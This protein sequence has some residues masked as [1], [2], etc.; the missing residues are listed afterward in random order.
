MGDVR[1]ERNKYEAL[2]REEFR[3][4]LRMMERGRKTRLDWIAEEFLTEGGKSSEEW[5]RRAFNE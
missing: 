5:L 2:S 3:N 4:M 1:D